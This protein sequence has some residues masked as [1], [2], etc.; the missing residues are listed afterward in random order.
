MKEK[1][2][3]VETRS[4]KMTRLAKEAID[5]DMELQYSEGRIMDILHEIKK[6]S[7]TKREINSRD[8][9]Y[10]FDSYYVG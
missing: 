5:L 3:K 8:L 4:S 7:P 1:K 2:E 6:M 9:Q 10:L